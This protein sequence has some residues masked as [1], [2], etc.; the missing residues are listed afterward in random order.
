MIDRLVLTVA[1]ARSGTKYAARVWRAAGVDVR[2]ELMGAAGTVSC[3]M[4]V[5][6]LPPTDKTAHVERAKHVDGI[7]FRDVRFGH[8]LHQV[9]HPLK[10]VASNE[11]TIS[12]ADREWMASIIDL[13]PHQPRLRWAIQY[14]LRWNRLCAARKPAMRYRV[15]AM[16][17]VWPELLKL[18]RLPS[19]PFP[20]KINKRTHA[21]S[22]V[23]KA[24]VYSW[25]ELTRQDPKGAEELRA[26]ARECGYE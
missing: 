13:D 21:S 15:E 24:K 20:E 9:R 26:F 8:V 16:G 3:F 19:V 2:H 1:T 10:V 18:L 6:V 11:K 4:A 25:E 22:G 23:R 5:D 14:A 7:A 17:E 12:R